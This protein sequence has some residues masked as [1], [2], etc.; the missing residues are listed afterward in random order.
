MRRN[1]GSSNIVVPETAVIKDKC[2]RSSLKKCVLTNI[3]KF[4]G[5]HLSLLTATL[6]KKRLWRRC[7]PVNFAKF[8]KNT[9]S[10]R[11]PPVAA[12]GVLNKF[13]KILRTTPVLVSLWVTW[14]FLR[15]TPTLVFSWVFCKIF[16]NKF[17]NRTPQGFCCSE[18]FI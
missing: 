4:T 9:F 15:E 11:T 12:S 5:K 6:L 14:V 10:Y 18:D 1:M 3:V 8:L 17:F 2:S 13:R 7:F 16:R